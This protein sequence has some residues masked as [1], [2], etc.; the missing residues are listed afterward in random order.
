METF[1][2]PYHGNPGNTPE[3]ASPSVELRGGF[4]FSSVPHDPIIRTYELTFPVMGY[5]LLPS[6]EPDTE[7]T[8]HPQWNIAAL[9]RFYERHGTY[10]TF[11]YPH[12]FW[13]DRT[14]RFDRPFTTPQVTGNKG[15][16]T[17]ITVSLRE[18]P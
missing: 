15:K 13:G 5:F 8:V 10:K 4:R 6:G 16:V 7:G 9:T 14:V 11:I 3:D 2:F 17:N 18:H 12:P 1:D